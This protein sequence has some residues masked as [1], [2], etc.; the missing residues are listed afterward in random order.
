MLAA[1]RADPPAFDANE[2]LQRSATVLVKSDELDRMREKRDAY[3]GLGE[4]GVWRDRVSELEA[5]LEAA[6][7]AADRRHWAG[8]DL[9]DD[10]SLEDMRWAFVRAVERCVL[11][12]G[13]GDVERR[14]SLRLRR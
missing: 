14:V 8:P 1:V 2:M 7:L 5:E 13:R 11:A 12:P 4:L 6:R 10:M 3:E 9:S